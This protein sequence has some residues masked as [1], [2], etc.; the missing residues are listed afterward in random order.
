MKR[1]ITAIS[2]C[3]FSLFFQ[4]SAFAGTLCFSNVKLAYVNVGF[5][6]G[7]IASADDGNGIYIGY[8][9]S[10]GQIVE[11]KVNNVM[12]LN[13]GNK[14]LAMYHALSTA[15]ALGLRVSGWDHNV[16]VGDSGSCDDFDVVRLR[17]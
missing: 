1:I 14:G 8:I 11:S 6:D 13:D 17:N 15:L 9:G 7:S 4:E 10:S 2:L 16:I 5:V 3:T 12:N